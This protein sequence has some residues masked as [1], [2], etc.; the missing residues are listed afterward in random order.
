MPGSTAAIVH[1]EG[2]SLKMEKQKQNQVVS[3]NGELLN[4]PVPTPSLSL[5]LSAVR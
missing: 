5:S 4:Q 2:A 1:H 3:D